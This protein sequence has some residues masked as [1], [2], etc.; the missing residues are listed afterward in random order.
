MPSTLHPAIA[1]ESPAPFSMARH[2][3]ILGL[4]AAAGP[5]GTDL[6]L[7]FFPAIG[8]DLSASA[9][10]LELSLVGYFAALAL[11]Q[12]VYGPLADRY[13]RR[14]PLL[15]GFALA[16][17]ASIG[18]A[19]APTIEAL[20][21]WR[22][23]QGL[24]ACAGM[25]ITR[26]IVRD[27]GGGERAARLF[28]FITMVLGVS[29]ILAPSFGTALLSVFPWQA[30]FWCMAAVA[31]ACLAGIVFGLR[32]TLAVANRSAG[33]AP[34]FAVYRQ[35]LRDRAYL[36]AVAA[37]AFALAGFFAYLGGSPNV[38]FGVHH[39]SA[40][41]YSL[42]F[43]VNAVALIGVS[44]LLAPLLRRASAD[45]LVGAVA[46]A[47]ALLSLALLAAAATG[48]DNL[49][50]TTTLLFLLSAGAGLLFPLT[51]MQA[52]ERHPLAAGAASAMMG[53]IQFGCGTLATM[54]LSATGAAS[55]MPLAAVMAL[56][57]VCA[58]LVHR[59]APASTRRP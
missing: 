44:L 39:V 51:S 15:I 41:Q 23:V 43:G 54:A 20:I 33:L 40:T 32:E 10:Q 25:V 9:G 3:V 58:C 14:W 37:G 48:L 13:G 56:C 12:L 29:P 31:A 52:V 7:P 27:L 4:L 36:R 1:G 21:Q 17:A 45:R 16:L 8:R 57:A 26:S 50:V 59:I 19:L 53:A 2:A 18:A 42:L 22:F 35:L 24:G 28:S 47:Q 6:Y 30:A 5:I 11:G 38:F 46:Q 49:A 55:A 34:A